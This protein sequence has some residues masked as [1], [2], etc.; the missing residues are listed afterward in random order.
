MTTDEKGAIA[1]AKIIAAAV[2][3]RVPVLQPVNDGLR[4]DLVF[5]LG[6]F[7]RVQCKWASRRGDVFVVPF[8]TCRRNA[9]GFLRTRYSSTEVDVVAAYFAEN[10]RCYLLPMI[11]F[12]GRTMVSLRLAPSRNNQREG[13]NWAKD[14]E[15]EATLR[16][17]GP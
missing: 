16:R 4:Y 13:V 7:L 15:M 17:L 9:D 10:D 8:R 14:Y 12:D 3:L 2:A 5:Y 6:R 1:Q 11:E